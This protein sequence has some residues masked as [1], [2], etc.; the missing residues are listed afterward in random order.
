M[1]EM[2]ALFGKTLDE[3]KSVVAELK[4]P[5]FTAKQIAEW[6][7][8]K[9][10]SA[11]SEMT[12][13]SLAARKMLEE[14]YVFGTSAPVQ[15]QVSKDGTKKYLFQVSDKSC[16][17]AVFIPDKERGTLCISSQ[18]GC[19]MNCAFCATG[20]QG[21]TQ[22]LTAGQIVNQICSLPEREQLT[23]IVL[24][25]MGEPMDN[26]DEVQK[27]LE[28]L[29][30]PWGLGM[31]PRR[32]TVSTVGVIPEMIRFIEN[33]ECHLAISL[34]SPFDEQRKQLMPVQAAYPIEKVLLFLRKYDWAHQRRLSFEYI[35]F[36]NLND[37]SL[38]LEALKKLLKGLDCRVNLIRYHEHEGGAFKSSN[39]A[40][41]VR[42]RDE[43]TKAGVITTIRQS[44]GEDIDAACGLLA[45]TKS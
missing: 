43:L 27:A 39:E 12:N 44:R 3:L 38:H 37:S 4:L 20:Q 10:C 13:L 23:N 6:L 8:Q 2:Q 32:I 33:S 1:P 34:H 14:H 5:A 29:T 17:E 15:E 21:F 11:F 18:V 30:E 31:S 24:M 40:T 9:H 35:M 19:R 7:Y 25:G 45:Q 42:F 36:R 26:L 22:H 28:I 41:M 16:V